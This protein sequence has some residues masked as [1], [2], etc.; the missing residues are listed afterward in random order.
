[1]TEEERDT[2]FRAKWRKYFEQRDAED[3]AAPQQ[4]DEIRPGFTKLG[5]DWK[6]RESQ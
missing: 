6:D 2:A 4:E 1:M 3:A 5:R